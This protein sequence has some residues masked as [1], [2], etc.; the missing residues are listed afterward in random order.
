MLFLI[1][2]KDKVRQVRELRVRNAENGFN[3]RVATMLSD[4]TL[5]VSRNC[6]YMYIHVYTNLLHLIH[7]H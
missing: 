6:L 3:E 1:I 5:K 4:M 2:L 7:I